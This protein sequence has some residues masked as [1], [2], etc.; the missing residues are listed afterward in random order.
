M[1][2]IVMKTNSHEINNISFTDEI[3][4]DGIC[5]FMSIPRNQSHLGMWKAFLKR[6]NASY[7]VK[8]L[9]LSTQAKDIVYN[10]CRCLEFY[11][12]EV[13]TESG[14]ALRVILRCGIFTKGRRPYTCKGFP[15]KTDSFMY[16]VPAPCVYN[17]YLAHEDYVRLKYT[18]VFRLFYA[19][20]DDRRLLGKIFPGR[21][22]EETREKL[23]RCK[24]VVKISAVWNEKPS[25]YFLLEV[26]KTKTVLY[27]SDAHP[28]IEGVKHA[29]DLWQGHIEGWL[30]KHYGSKWQANLADAMKKENTVKRI[31]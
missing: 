3:C 26:P 18:H 6:R 4:A 7:G 25:E 2:N 29:Y 9:Y 20:K 27:I 16:D 28:K 8:L 11:L 24:E 21:T 17:E 10:P 12:K 23:N 15:D 14:T 19:I 1:K 5:C 22:A 13:T 30:E 31:K